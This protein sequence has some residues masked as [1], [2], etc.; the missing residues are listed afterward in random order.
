MEMG[1]DITERKRAEELLKTANDELTQRARQLRAMTSELANAEDRERRRLAQMLHDHLQQLLVGAKFSIA[2]LQ[3]KIQ[4][5]EAKDSLVQVKDLL[6]QCIDA[7]RSLTAELAPPILYD[8]G[9]AEALRWLARWMREKH[10]LLIELDL[11]DSADIPVDD[12]LLLFQAAR[13]LLFNVVKHARV[14]QA[15]VHLSRLN[16]EQI[17]LVVSDQGI[18]LAPTALGRDG[19]VAGGFG[20]FNIRERV[21]WVGGRVEIDTAPKQGTRITLVLPVELEAPLK[22]SKSARHKPLR[23]K[24]ASRAKGRRVRIMLVDDHQIVREGLAQLL[25]GIADCEVIGEA[26]DGEMAVDL[27]RRLHPDVVVMDVSM[28]RLNGIEATR[29]I[30]AEQ[31]DCRIIGLSMHQQ[32]DMEHAMREAGAVAYL[33]KDGPSEALIKAIRGE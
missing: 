14:N 23:A 17:R 26:E 13:E 28:P 31:P 4:E 5:H 1:V 22:L 29:I 21:E 19:P 20:L 7:S 15:K 8:G 6:T 30:C 24:P 32:A 33:A 27:A 9:T 25:K 3:M 10:N 18:G 2:T 16:G 12:R 11:D